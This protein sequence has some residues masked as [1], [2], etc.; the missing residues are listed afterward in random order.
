MNSFRM[1]TKYIDIDVD[2]GL[3]MNLSWRKIRLLLLHK[4]RLGCRATE[5]TDKRCSTMGENMLSIRT[6]Q[7]WFNRFKNGNLKLDDLLRSSGSLQ[8][9]V[10]LL[11]QLIEEDLPRLTS[12]H[13]KQQLGC[14]H[15]AMEK[16]LNKLGKT[17]IYKVWIP[18]QVSSHY[19]RSIPLLA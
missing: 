18:H 3:K 14:S 13:L 7:Q 19:V 9:E 10:G 5:A 17:W 6:V 8:Q 2:H 15:T 1:I 12:R 16:H 4:F 11:N